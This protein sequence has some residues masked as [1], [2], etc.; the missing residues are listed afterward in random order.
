M[1]MDRLKGGRRL[2]RRVVFDRGV[3]A[4]GREEGAGGEC[5]GGRANR[6]QGLEWETGM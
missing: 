1:R 6:G 4:G 2:K 5:A 3:T